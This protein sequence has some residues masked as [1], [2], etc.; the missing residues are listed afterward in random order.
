MGR[1]M[2]VGCFREYRVV[3]NAT[4]VCES[5]PRGVTRS[6]VHARW[7]PLEGMSTALRR[8]GRDIGVSV[9]VHV[10]IHRVILCAGGRRQWSWRRAAPQS[11]ELF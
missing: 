6:L 1:G 2:T 7:N 4:G 5:S 9:L 3:R 11:A 8:C 10:Y